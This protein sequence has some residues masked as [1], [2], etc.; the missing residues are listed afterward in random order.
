MKFVPRDMGEAAE[1]SAGEGSQ[2]REL[3]KLTL[4]ALGLIIAL[5]LIVGLVVDAVVLGI[6]PQTEARLFQGFTSAFNTMP[7]S[8]DTDE[9]LARLQAIL[10]R[11]KIHPEV[12]AIEY[13]LFLLPDDSP[14]AFAVPGGGI[15]VTQGLLDLLEEDASLAFVLGHELG[16][17]K[18]RDHLRGMGRGIGISICY[19]LVFGGSSGGD[20][21]A[22]NAVNFM[23]QH[24]S[25]T[26]EEGADRFGVQ[27]VHAAYGHTEGVEVLFEK[28]LEMNDLPKWAYMFATHPDSASR[29]RNMQDYAA[30]LPAPPAAIEDESAP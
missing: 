7:A 27:L 8:P 24:Y 10:D 4:W 11:L 22:G 28:L 21:I 14:N 15:G 29:I 19:A 26:Q 13:T 20:M 1:A 12:P 16:H 25:R 23:N 2:M 9:D 3:V 18:Q 5:Y 30:T 17:F 6:S